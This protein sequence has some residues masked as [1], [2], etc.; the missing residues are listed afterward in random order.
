[1]RIV[2]VALASLVSAALPARAQFDIRIPDVQVPGVTNQQ[3]AARNP[4]SSGQTGKTLEQINDM[5]R[6][7]IDQIP[8][9]FG[10]IPAVEQNRIKGAQ[11][12]LDKARASLTAAHRLERNYKVIES[13]ITL[14][15]NEITSAGLALACSK[16][17]KD[18]RDLHN[19]G[20]P[21][22]AVQL[23]ALED[24]VTAF[25]QGKTKG[26]DDVVASFSKRASSAREANPRIAENEAQVAR[27]KQKRANEQKLKEVLGEANAKKGA[28]EQWLRQNPEGSIPADL[29]NAFDKAVA[30]VT[31]VN[32]KA[33]G[34]YKTERT[35]IEIANAWRLD[36][37]EAAS[38]IGKLMQGEVVASGQT[39][40]KTL[41]IDV[42]ATKDWCY[43]LAMRFASESGGEKIERFDW[44]ASGANS[45]LQR[46]ETFRGINS[47]WQRTQGVCT[48]A[49]AKVT[50]TAN[51]VFA[52]SRNGVRYV[53]VGWP[54]PKFP[55]FESTYLAVHPQDQCD[56]VAWSELW[57]KPIPGSVVFIGAEPHL[58]QSTD[59]PGQQWLTL[60]NAN[61]QNDVRAQKETITSTPPK[62]RAFKTQFAFGDCPDIGG[63]KHPDSVKLAK[64]HQN[65]DKRYQSAIDATTHERDAARTAGAYRAAVAKLERLNDKDGDDRARECGPIRKV[66][67]KKAAKAFGDIVDWHVDNA[68]DDHL[69]RAAQLQEENE[70]FVQ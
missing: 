20:K 45:S 61:G 51:L 12:Q 54:K 57:T 64:C 33:G 39:T 66:I 32:A 46:Y 19:L 21:A 8:K 70:A 48:T 22:S 59:S 47:V 50:A 23:Q 4:T 42:N 1:V 65:I 40:G 10:E 16:A 29:M 25:E 53:V 68:Y 58:I 36:N 67:E 6:S 56:T 37:E 38:R 41:K 26:W 30:A 52:G 27:N 17:A 7:G 69:D 55:A 49:A 24:A 2:S 5:L 31:A 9:S 35:H 11:E 63:A 3:G 60:I 13:N 18:I 43:S 15:E 44:N 62:V 28:I 14:L 34:Y